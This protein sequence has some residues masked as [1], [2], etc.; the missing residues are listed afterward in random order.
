MR[1]RNGQPKQPPKR[2]REVNFQGWY[3]PEDPYEESV[4][5][6][7]TDIQI[8]EGLTPKQ[9]IARAVLFAAEAAGFEVATP[10]AA[11]VDNRIE[12]LTQLVNRLMT[13]IENGGFVAA[14]PSARQA[15]EEDA[16]E[17]DAISRSVGS[18]YR[19]MSF[20]DED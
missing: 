1:R 8:K 3:D 13:M 17:F 2:E 14:N 11:E 5:K 9:I 20:E 4:I 12:Q 6:A 10:P 18:R 19:P 16:Q 15:F 7:F